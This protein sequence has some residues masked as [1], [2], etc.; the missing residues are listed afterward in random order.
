M[1][2]AC[3]SRRKVV[4]TIKH[5]SMDRQPLLLVQPLMAD[6]VSFDGDPQVAVD[7]MGAGLGQMV[8]VTS[9][10]AHARELLQADATPVR[11]SIIGIEDD[12]PS[13]T[14]TP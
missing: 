9:D 11:W 12:Q 7:G 14:A 8:M 6:G 1:H 3:S 5:G 2:A 13:A 4:S 10:G